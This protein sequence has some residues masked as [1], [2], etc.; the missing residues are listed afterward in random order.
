MSQIRR[1]AQYAKVI[2][3]DAIGISHIAQGKV[4]LSSNS[5]NHFVMSSGFGESADEVA[6]FI[7]PQDR[8]GGSQGVDRVS[9]PGMRQV[10]HGPDSDLRTQAW[11]VVDGFIEGRPA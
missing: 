9:Y 5:E 4:G 8:I 6:A 2:V 3:D 11:V 1:P 7:W 10:L